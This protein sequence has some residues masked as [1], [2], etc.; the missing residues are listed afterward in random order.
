VKNKGYS[1]EESKWLPAE[2]LA[3][4]Q[5]MVREFYLLHLNQPK[6]LGSGTRSHPEIRQGASSSTESGRSLY[7]VATL[8]NMDS[9]KAQWVE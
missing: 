1:P 8:A 4:A 7:G 9:T 5:D 6:L 3:N 2:N